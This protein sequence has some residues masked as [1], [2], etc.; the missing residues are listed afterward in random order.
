MKKAILLPL[1]LI[2][3]FILYGCSEKKESTLPPRSISA[4]SNGSTEIYTPFIL[5][6]K[7]ISNS[8]F[9]VNGNSLI[10]PNREDN[11]KISIIQEP[12]PKNLITTSIISDFMDYSTETLT[13]INDVIYFADASNGNNLSSINL[14]DKVYKKINNNNVHNIISSNESL[15]YINSNDKNK[16][17]TYNIEEGS[18]SAITSDSIGEY[19]L[20]GDFILYQNLSDNSNLYTIKIDG[21]QKQQVTDFSVNSFVPYNGEIL[22]INSS[23]NN[24]LYAVNPSDL[25]SRRLALMNGEKLKVHDNSLY[26]INLDDANYLYS[27]S[28]NLE[29]SEI[30]SRAIVKDGINDYFPTNLG[31]FLEKR[32]NVN[33][34][35]IIDTPSQ[36]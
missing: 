30:S 36:P 35:Y 14:S 22:V 34:T 6:D 31:I 16:L 9:V 21:S 18:S 11:N 4:S 7:T 33:N 3:T 10:F 26:F 24:N 12:Y 17:Y 19:L 25:K 20:N 32:S 29:T 8:P 2:P 13:V 23:D 15:F 27:L 5:N 28:V 1:L